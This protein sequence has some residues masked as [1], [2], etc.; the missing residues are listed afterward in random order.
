M[1]T[2]PCARTCPES[3][4]PT[5]CSKHPTPGH[6]RRILSTG[7]CSSCYVRRRR[8]GRGH[9]GR[10]R[11]DVDV[12]EVV[13]LRATWGEPVRMNSLERLEVVRELTRR[14]LSVDE[15]AQRMR[16]TR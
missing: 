13:V 10:P 14:G 5:I 15:I 4:H 11:A 6:R 12:D 1:M 16:I 2:H 3:G 9:V 8:Y 7:M